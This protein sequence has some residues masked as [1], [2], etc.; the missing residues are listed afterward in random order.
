MNFESTHIF[1]LIPVTHRT[2]LLL[3]ISFS[4]SLFSFFFSFNLGVVAGN[5]N[6]LKNIAAVD[7][8]NASDF[9]RQKGLAFIECS[10]K[11]NLDVSSL[12]EEI[13]KQT[14]RQFEER[15]EAL[16]LL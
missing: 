9:A 15:V 3:L 13:A 5:K 7:S 6:D 8:N 14:C 11:E 12:F 2:N 10:A 4:L 1:Y 16:K